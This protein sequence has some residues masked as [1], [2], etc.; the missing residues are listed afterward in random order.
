MDRSELISFYLQHIKDNS[1]MMAGNHAKLDIY[2]GNLLPYVYDTMKNTLSAGYF[3]KIKERILPINVLTRITD[4][5]AKVYSDSPIRTATE[6]K[7]QEVVDLWVVESGMDVHMNM[8]DV[9]SHLFKGYALEPYIKDGARHMRA[10]PFDRFLP[11]SRDITDPCRMTD[12]IKFMGKMKKGSAHVEVYYAY[13]DTDFIAFD[14]TGEEIVAAYK[15]NDGVN[16]YGVIPF[17]YGGRSYTSLIPKQDTDIIQ[18]TKMIPVILSDLGGA[19]MFQCFSIIYGIDLNTEGVVMAPNAL[20]NFKSAANLG[21]GSRPSVGT[22]N[23]SADVQK[24]L[25]F[26]RNTFVLWLETKGVRIGSVNNIDAGNATSGIAKIIDEMDVYEI[27]KQAI[28]YFK[29]EERKLWE[30]IGVIETHASQSGLI[31][32][33]YVLGEDFEVITEFD[34]PRPEIGRREQVEIAA[35]EVEKGFNTRRRAVMALWPDLSEKEIEEILIEDQSV[36][37]PT[38]GMNGAAENGNTDP[39]GSDAE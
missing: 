34:E 22:I 27:K 32:D 12:F 18:L 36:E 13:T 21:E 9:F 19:V 6:E 33:G 17:I 35:L 14:E 7:Y 23:P 15:D 16:P 3:E 30:L 31:E 1:V 25:E 10:I 24:V 38:E 5:L 28:Q 37:V 26:V 29:A 11:I 20:W 39:E 8:A 4:K 2:E